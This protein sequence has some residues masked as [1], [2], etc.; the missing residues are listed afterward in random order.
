MFQLFSESVSVKKNL[1][2]VV[3]PNFLHN[4]LVETVSYK[5][6]LFLMEK[7]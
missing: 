6:N 1:V 7:L 4:L 5:W 3:V 2:V